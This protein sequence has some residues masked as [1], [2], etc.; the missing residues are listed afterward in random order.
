LPG[1]EAQPSS[2]LCIDQM[3]VFTGFFILGGEVVTLSSRAGRH[4]DASDDKRNSSNSRR[5]MR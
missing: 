1:L 5:R 2:S 3:V 4:Q